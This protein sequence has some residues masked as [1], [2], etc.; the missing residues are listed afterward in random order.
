V[1]YWPVKALPYGCHRDKTVHA[2]S[3]KYVILKVYETG[4]IPGS[5]F[6]IG[7]I[8]GFLWEQL[9]RAILLRE[10]KDRQKMLEA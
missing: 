4:L 6:L 8:A 3:T 5:V 2:P 10:L 7:T 9:G 1:T